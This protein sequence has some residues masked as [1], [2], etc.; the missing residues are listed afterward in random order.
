[1][2]M[3]WQ[4]E[5]QTEQKILST[6][7]RGVAQELG[8]GWAYNPSEFDTHVSHYVTG[9]N[10]QKIGLHLVWN[11]KDRVSVGGVLENGLH[12]FKRYNDNLPDITVAWARG[13]VVVANEIRR[14]VLP[15]Y[16]EVLGRAMESKQ[17]SEQRERQTQDNCDQLAA[18]LAAKGYCRVSKEKDF[19]GI[20]EGD[21][22]IRHDYITITVSMDTERAKIILDAVTATRKGK[23]DS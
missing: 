8:A 6:L 11:H 20:D 2:S 19:I 18:L 14:R 9:P 7:A 22:K 23:Q 5:Q 15:A 21:I 3:T 12:N 13:P 16:V 10:H 4:E 17:A 1:M